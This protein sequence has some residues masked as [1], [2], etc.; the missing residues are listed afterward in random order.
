MLLVVL[1]TIPIFNLPVFTPTPASIYF[2][3]QAKSLVGND[4]TDVGPPEK[5]ASYDTSTW[6]GL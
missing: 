6:K 5:L 3:S 1:W 2:P 4:K